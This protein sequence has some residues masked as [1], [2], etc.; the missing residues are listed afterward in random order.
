MKFSTREDTDIPADVLFDSISNFARAEKLLIRR[1]ASVRRIDPSQEPGAGMAWLVGFDWRGKRREL[2]LDVVQFDRPER[3]SIAGMADSYQIR[4]DMTVIALT[5]QKS[6]LIV[7]TEVRPRNMRARL[8][9]QT[10]KLGKSQLDQR[11]AKQISKYIQ[12]MTDSRA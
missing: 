5:R 8:V 1:G 12:E 2:R 6:R 10:A 3:L 9:L 11:Y 4:L 7:E